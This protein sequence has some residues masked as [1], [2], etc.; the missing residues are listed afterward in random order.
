MSEGVLEEQNKGGAGGGNKKQRL[1]EVN[2]SRGDLG[3]FG[4]SE[5]RSALYDPGERRS[6]SQPQNTV[7]CLLLQLLRKPSSRPAAGAPRCARA[8]VFV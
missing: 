4:E 3:V 8:G 1:T 6:A 7:V 5:E 2:S